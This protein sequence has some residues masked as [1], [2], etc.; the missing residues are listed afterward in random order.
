MQNCSTQKFSNLFM[1]ENHLESLL[2]YHFLRPTS[3]VFNSVDLGYDVGYH[4]RIFI[5]TK[6]P[7]DADVVGPGFT[8][9]E[10]LIYSD[11]SQNNGYLWG[12]RKVGV[13]WKGAHMMEMF[14]I[15]NQ[16]VVM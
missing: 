3:G 12:C 15:L 14:Y 2:K 7:G 11:R 9:L 6:F 10:V 16:V 8:F 5:S 1:K 4:L 13:N